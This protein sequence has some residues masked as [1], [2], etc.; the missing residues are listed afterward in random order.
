MQSA[1]GSYEEDPIDE[2]D[3]VAFDAWRDE[4]FSHK[5][6]DGNSDV[7]DNL[8]QAWEA[9]IGPRLAVTAENAM[10]LA[11]NMALHGDSRLALALGKVLQPEIHP[12]KSLASIRGWRVEGVGPIREL[13]VE[14]DFETFEIVFWV[15]VTHELIPPRR[16]LKAGPFWR[17]RRDDYPLDDLR[18]WLDRIYLAAQPERSN[19][20]AQ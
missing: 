20:R 7:L 12:T 10:R 16:D 4:V 13:R 1:D 8:L 14:P 15:E 9:T 11:I 2:M 3:D 19:T 5:R 6:H 17:F 18:A